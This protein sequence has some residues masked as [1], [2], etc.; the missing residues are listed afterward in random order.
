MEH[1]FLF[2][3]RIP[4]SWTQ[5][6]KSISLFRV[7]HPDSNK[8]VCN[9]I[10]YDTANVPIRR[11]SFMIKLTRDYFSE[12]TSHTNALIKNMVSLNTRDIQRPWDSGYTLPPIFNNLDTRGLI[13]KYDN[14]SLPLSLKA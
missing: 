14:I 8:Y 4:D 3:G 2:R 12:L 10:L 6:S 7:S 11:D 1:E 5:V 13:Q 9:K